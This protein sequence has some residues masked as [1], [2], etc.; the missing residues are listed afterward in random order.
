MVVPG[1]KVL[2][3]LQRTLCMIG[4][5]S[6]LISQTRRSKI[7]ETVDRSW[8]KFGSDNFPSAKDT[9][10]EIFTPPSQARWKKT[11]HSPR[12]LRSQKSK[13]EKETST[14]SS[15]RKEQRNVTFFFKGAFQPSTEAGRARASSRTLHILI[16]TEKGISI[17]GDG[18]PSPT[19]KV[20]PLPRAKVTTG[21]KSET[22]QRKF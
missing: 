2:T 10:F 21:P 15:R 7:L 19:G 3:L 17:K 4:N 20:A 12:Q 22:P 13:R 18:S 1:S 8:S 16:R 11:L 6:Q 14:F 5:A 9:L